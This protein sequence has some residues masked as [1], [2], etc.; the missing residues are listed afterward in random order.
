MSDVKTTGENVLAGPNA[1]YRDRVVR[2][3]A[4]LTE[5]ESLWGELNLPPTPFLRV[6]REA[7]SAI[8]EKVNAGQKAL[9]EDV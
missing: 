1:D 7:V 6:L 2:L 5:L 8:V 3:Q 9:P 4:L